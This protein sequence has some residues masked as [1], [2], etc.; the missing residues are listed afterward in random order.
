MFM[1]IS[2]IKNLFLIFLLLIFSCK[3]KD[4]I[5]NPTNNNGSQPAVLP[6][7]QPLDEPSFETIGPA[8]GVL[9]SAD[10]QITIEIPAGALTQDRYIGIQPI[11]NTAISGLGNGYRITPHG[12]IFKKKGLFCSWS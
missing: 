8:G 9:K 11:K 7:G 12:K 10:G 4:V 5:D 3:K 6:I 2:K 1:E